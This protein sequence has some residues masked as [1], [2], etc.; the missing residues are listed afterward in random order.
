MG[1]LLK[2][3]LIQA[4]LILLAVPARSELKTARFLDSSRSAPL[5]IQAPILKVPLQGSGG[6]IV[7]FPPSTFFPTNFYFQTKSVFPVSDV[8]FYLADYYS[9]DP[10]NPSETIAYTVDLLIG[11]CFYQFAYLNVNPGAVDLAR[12][13]DD[14]S[15]NFYVVLSKRGG[16]STVDKSQW[17]DPVFAELEYYCDANFH[18]VFVK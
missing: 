8:K 7:C 18:G 15:P 1:N 14:H 4:V 10:N 12:A 17:N 16:C 3:F 9:Q 6:E 2:A 5:T 13:I 11:K